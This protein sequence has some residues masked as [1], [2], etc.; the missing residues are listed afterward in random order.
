[1]SMLKQNENS[2]NKLKIIFSSKVKEF[3]REYR[4]FLSKKT[5][6]TS[7]LTSAKS[8]LKSGQDYLE[9]LLKRSRNLA[10][11]AALREKAILE[12]K[13]IIITLYTIQVNLTLLEHEPAMAKN[14]GPT[15]IAD[16]NNLVKSVQIP[17]I[18]NALDEYLYEES[19]KEHVKMR[20]SKENFLVTKRRFIILQSNISRSSPHFR[21]TQHVLATNVYHNPRTPCISFLNSYPYLI[22][23]CQTHEEKCQHLLSTNLAKLIDEKTEVDINNN[24]MLANLIFT[25]D[26]G[27]RLLSEVQELLTRLTPGYFSYSF[28]QRT[29]TIEQY[30]ETRQNDSGLVARSV[31]VWLSEKLTLLDFSHLLP[32]LAKLDFIIKKMASDFGAEDANLLEILNAINNALSFYCAHANADQRPVYVQIIL[33]QIYNHASTKKFMPVLEEE[34]ANKMGQ[35]IHKFDPY[36]KESAAKLIAKAQDVLE[37]TSDKFNAIPFYAKKKKE[38]NTVINDKHAPLPGV[39]LFSE[40]ISQKTHVHLST[41]FG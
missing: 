24:L 35:D 11:D 6:L 38:L 33:A 29:I 26:V 31:I 34:L 16:L 7:V 25:A 12:I 36:D 19:Q 32:I 20:S 37:F 4:A 27:I 8:V 3:D 2:P 17:Q 22:R 23:G 30:L 39:V 40:L 41:S 14:K 15:L 9:E 1:M 21:A 5:L 13:P 10:L 28:Y 18:L